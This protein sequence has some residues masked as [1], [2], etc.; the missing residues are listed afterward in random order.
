MQKFQKLSIGKA[1]TLCAAI[2]FVLWAFS[3]GPDP[4][5]TGAPGDQTCVACHL[6]TVNSGPGR[7]TITFPSGNTYTPGATQRITVRVEDPNQRRWGFQLSAR[8]ASNE[9][10]GQAG[11]FRSVD[12]NTQVLCENGRPKT[13]D[14]ACPAAAPLE[15]V[16]H[17]IAGTRMGTTGGTNFDFE[18]TAPAAGAGDVVFYV[19][20]NA[21]NGDA[22]NTGDRV[23]T[24]NVR[25]TPA[26]AAGPRPSISQNGVVNGASFAAPIAPKAWFTVRGENLG[27]SFTNAFTDG[28]YPTEVSGVRVLVNDRP[29]PLYFSNGT[30]INALVP[31][32]TAVGP[33]Q[34]VVVREGQRSDGA[35]VQMERLAP[36]FFV[37]PQNQ[38]VATD[39]NFALK[40]KAGTFPNAATT[41]ARPEEVIILWGTGFGPTNPDVPAGRQTPSDRVHPVTTVPTIRIG[42]VA[43][44]YIAGALAPGFAGLYQI[45][46]RVPGTLQNGDHAIVAE[47][48]GLSSPANITLTVQR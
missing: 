44:E 47:A 15:F 6:G 17:T 2:P 14:Q 34:V 27:A 21:A 13:G 12:A 33:V 39:P 25:L 10:I 11:A 37:W 30:Q 19:A 8:L 22:N 46:V 24:A 28:A 36:A 23:Y 18:W 9:R 35:T 20:G 45:A 48:G 4:R 32:D 1:V 43:A 38:A 29:A 3:E 41:P 16:E 40:A 42:G 7:V 31:D 5:H 26:A